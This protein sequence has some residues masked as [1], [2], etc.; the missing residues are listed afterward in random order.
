MKKTGNAATAKK[1]LRRIGRYK[2]FLLLSVLLAAAAVSFT[3]Y[4]PILIGRAIDCIAGAGQVD[5][6]GLKPYL[7]KIAAF[8]GA[9]GL[10]Q[11][12]M[13]TVNNRI[14]FYV[15][16]DVRNE[17]FE[18]I[19]SLP[20]K[21]LDSRSAGDT[22]N[23]VTADAD[24]FADGLLIGFT[25]L[26]TGMA[27]ILGTLG[28]MLAVNRKIALVVV[29]L[30]PL[31]L[32][33]ARFIASRTYH[34]F[35]EQSKTRAEQTAFVEEMIGEA[36]TVA[37]FSR[38]EAAGQ[39]FD[40]I[41]GRLEKTSLKA[42][43]FSS[44]TN[45]TTRFVNSAVYAAV[46]LTG[47]LAAAG[48]GFFAVGGAFTVGA[49]SSLLAYANQYTKPF[50]EI[51]GVI[52]ELQ[53]AFACAERLF[54][55]IEEPAETPDAPGAARLENVSGNVALENVDF[56]Y[57][58]ERPLIRDFNLSVKPG[59]RIAI[60]GP[61]G[62][63]KTTLINLLM[64]FY[65]VNGGSIR[66]ESEDI[67]QVTRESLRKS[68][69]MVLQDT[70]LRS[71]TIRENIL[72]GNPDA[73]EEEMISAAKAAHAHSFI[74]RLPDGYD[75]VIGENGGSLS[76]GQKQLLCITR[77]MLCPPPMLIL[78]EAT[79][80]ID[81]RTEI[82]IQQAF[83]RLMSGRTSFIVAHRLSTI[84]EADV[85]LVMNNGNIVEQG[86][87]DSL[88]AKNGFYARLYNSQFETGN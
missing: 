73:T 15:I 26:F 17:A 20:L 72:I 56:S 32:F 63:G 4:I 57:Q 10:V 67:R 51:S 45:P 9:V 52:T 60:V 48:V 33:V 58:P 77:I 39:Q 64:R 54:E 3:L 49:L 46:A 80:S 19:Q 82:K 61:T 29:I 30:T 27:T 13:N 11:W 65:D 75:T 62:C 7:I 76:Q 23:R 38:A 43:F 12:L 78:D 36:K 79:S 74:K 35:L 22:L 83:A 2:W 41:N 66:V 86:N 37:A 84:R 28:F 81:T 53:N 59:Q 34:L 50:N 44:L 85:I 16:R 18:R 69:G 55:L 71:G 87:H 6:G 5:F 70:W 68:Y 8:A 14:T 1:V 21:F 40:E 25:Q 31:S 42:T 88:L 24:Q 47:G